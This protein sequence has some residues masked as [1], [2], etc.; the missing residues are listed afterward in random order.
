MYKLGETPLE[1]ENVIMRVRM[2]IQ[3]PYELPGCQQRLAK[4]PTEGLMIALGHLHRVANTYATL[5][6]VHIMYSITGLPS[7]P[8]H[9][10]SHPPLKYC[11]KNVLR[12]EATPPKE[13]SGCSCTRAYTRVRSTPYL[14]VHSHMLIHTK[15]NL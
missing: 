10:K 8:K 6:G 5:P 7:Y 13:K 9:R 14:A 4:I 2:Y 12:H 3:T 15:L 11:L 1:L